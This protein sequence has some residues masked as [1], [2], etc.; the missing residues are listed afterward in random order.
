MSSSELFRR[1]LVLERVDSVAAD[2]NVRHVDQLDAETLELFYDALETDRSM[3]AE[4]AD[5]EVGEII[6]FTEYYR[7]ASA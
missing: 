1:P 4:N 3:R 6:V 5:L 2:A 7:V